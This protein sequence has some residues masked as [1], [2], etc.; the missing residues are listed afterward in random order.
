MNAV[1][2]CFWLQGSFE[3]NGVGDLSKEQAQVIQNHLNLVFKHEIDPMRE[4]ETTA[5]PTTLNTAHGGG[6]GNDTSFRC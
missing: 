1:D 2:F 6:Q 3:V 4:D 5:T